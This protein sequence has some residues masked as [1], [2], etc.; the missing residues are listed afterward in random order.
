L[1]IKDV[2]ENDTEEMKNGAIDVLIYYMPGVI[3]G[4]KRIAYGYNGYNVIGYFKLKI[5]QHCGLLNP[6]LNTLKTT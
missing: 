3:K 4:L 6:G 2:K 1:K 5:H